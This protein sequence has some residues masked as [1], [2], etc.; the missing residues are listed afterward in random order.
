M[1]N[2]LTFTIVG[3][4]LYCMSALAQQTPPAAVSAPYAGA[5]I[6]DF[7]GKVSIQLPAQAFTA[8]TRGE[9][10]PPDTT[11]STEDGRLLL[12][13]SDGSD[14]LV[15][16]NTKLVLKQPET[17]GWKYFQMVIGRV[18]TSIQKRMGGAPAFQIGTPSA[19]ISVRGT[20]FD[21]EVD[22]RGFTE[23]D[24][25]EGTVELE[26]LSGLGE[27]IMITAGFSSRVGMETGP[28]VPRPTR[29]LRPQLDRP[30]R[31]GNGVSIDDDPTKKLLASDH[32][33]NGDRHSGG[34]SSGSGSGSSGGSSGS[35][36]GSGDSSG[37]D[38]GSH[39]SG[40][41]DSSGGSGQS[42]SGSD[43]GSPSGSGD[44][45]SGSGD[46]HHHGGRPP[47]T[48]YWNWL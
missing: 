3:I 32:D 7:K 19:V 1:K 24:V 35:S 25:E 48:I 37:S 8:P 43:G 39:S 33:H 42:T 40:G 14:I 45:H 13:L 6:S 44:D 2:K 30:S 26:A 21:V 18:R 4:V 38:S 28:E 15:R 34:D 22:R 17:S 27:S 29:E 23:V 46:D 36:G 16:P 31:K 20:K 5:T 12:K 11:V 47:A 9:I 41:S 10:L